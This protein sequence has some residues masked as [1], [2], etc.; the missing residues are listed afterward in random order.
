MA[1]SEEGFPASNHHDREEEPLDR[2]SRERM[3]A[4]L[5]WRY[6]KNSLPGIISNNSLFLV[7]S[8][9]LVVGWSAVCAYWTEE[10]RSRSEPGSAQEEWFGWLEEAGRRFRMAGILFVF[11]VVF[12]F[13][14]CYDRW[15]EGRV[16]WEKIITGAK[17]L[18]RMNRVYVVD[19]AFAD[20]F[21]RFIVVFAYACKALLRGNTLANPMEAGN[22]LIRKGYLTNEELE[23]MEE[24]GASQ[25]QYCLDMLSAILVEAYYPKDALCFD[26]DH[27]AHAQILRGIDSGITKLGTCIG[28]AVRVHAAGLPVCIQCSFSCVCF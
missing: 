23:D 2:I 7:A 24:Y 8:L 28:A 11:S 3:L 9:V 20:R 18:A 25:P 19:N 4:R 5:N 17:D 21:S 26:V 14:R 16:L 22:D 6:L 1:S 27:K 12:R 13:N 10:L 15:W